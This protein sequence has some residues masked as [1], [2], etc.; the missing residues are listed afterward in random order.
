MRRGYVTFAEAMKALPKPGAS[1][2]DMI[3]LVNAI[4]DLGFDLSEY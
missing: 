2:E 1:E 4:F 3:A